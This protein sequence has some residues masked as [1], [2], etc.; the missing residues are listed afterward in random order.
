M[1]ER[2]CERE[3]LVR[4]TCE[5]VRVRE[6]VRETGDLVRVRETVRETGEGE[7]D[8]ERDW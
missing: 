7:G 2:D 6:T 4:E 8:S 3:L 1:G 5:W